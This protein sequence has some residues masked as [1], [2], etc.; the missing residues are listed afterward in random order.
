[1]LMHVSLAKKKK[2]ERILGTLGFLV[3]SELNTNGFKSWD[4]R[5][6]AYNIPYIWM[7]LNISDEVGF[8]LFQPMIYRIFLNT[9]NI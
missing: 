6:K 7:Q 4:D 1:M 5:S 8:H 9:S 3:H 2:V